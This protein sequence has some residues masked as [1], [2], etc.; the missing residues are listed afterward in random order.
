MTAVSTGLPLATSRKKSTTPSTSTTTVLPAHRA[1]NASLSVRFA[2][3]LRSLS[4]P[5]SSG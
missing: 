5:M 1:R 3:I 4:R 2:V